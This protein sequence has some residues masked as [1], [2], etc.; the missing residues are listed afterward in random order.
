MIKKLQ[1]DKYVRSFS[2]DRTYDYYTFIECLLKSGNLR[3]KHGFVRYMRNCR[4]LDRPRFDSGDADIDR[5]NA[6]HFSSDSE[7]SESEDD[8][9]GFSHPIGPNMADGS[10]TSSGSGDSSDE[11]VEVDSDTPII[12]VSRRDP[13]I[14]VEVQRL[15]VA[16]DSD[17]EGGA[18]LYPSDE[19]F[20]Q[21]HSRDVI[22]PRHAQD[23]WTSS[24][25]ERDR[26]HAEYLS[27][28]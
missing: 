23:R 16:N 17:S 9:R 19:V 15:P 21:F 20:Y 22:H 4:Y 1:D 26:L 6:E 5:A 28:D 7:D 18:S 10:E 2:W 12:A 3:C 24:D 11:E 27:A 13:S 25:N 14:R 8:V